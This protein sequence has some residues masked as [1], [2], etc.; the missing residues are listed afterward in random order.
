MLQF[1]LENHQKHHVKTF[2]RNQ[3]FYSFETS[4][5]FTKCFR[6]LLKITV[7]RCKNML[8]S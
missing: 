2:C 4:K 3:I 1:F 6:V 7:K 5:I 8:N